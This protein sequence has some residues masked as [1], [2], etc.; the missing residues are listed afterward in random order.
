MIQQVKKLIEEYEMIQEGDKVVLGVSGGADSVCLLRVLLEL[1]EELD[2]QLYVAHI[3]HGI[4]GEASL[5]DAEF[6]KQLCRRFSLP[7]FLYS[8]PVLELA[9]EKRISVEEAGRQVRYS[10]F[11]ELAEKIGG[12]KIAVAH[13]GNDV[14]ETML[15]HLARGTGLRGLAGIAPV[16][17]NIIRPLLEVTREE[18]LNYLEEIQQD[19]CTD[20]TNDMVDYARNRIRHQVLPALEQIN[21]KAIPHMIRTGRYVRENLKEQD[22]ILKHFWREYVRE[23]QGTIEICNEF[24]ECNGIGIQSVLVQEA[25]CYQSGHRK[26]IS[27]A[28]I[29]AVIHLYQ[30]QIGK[31]VDLPYG[32]EACRQYGGILLEKHRHPQEEQPTQEPMELKVPG[33]TRLLNGKVMVTTKILERK[34]DFAEIPRKKYTKWFDY[35]IIKNT[36][37]VRT[38]VAGDYL[39]VD[40]NG[41]RKK[42][43]EYLINEKVPQNQREQQLLIA[44]GSLVHWVVGLR[45]GEDAKVKQDT[46]KILEIQINGGEEYERD[47]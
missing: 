19:Y 5:Q 32:M 38:R 4:R 20:Q 13:N 45:I 36:L 42:L 33:V 10:S 23:E 31:T 30:G 37:Q 9:K 12:G 2:I 46:R 15:F 17:N 39:I 18:I 27:A 47:N 14:A 22:E 25:I 29:E 7:F 44:E 3:E 26:D 6:V 21:E 8:Y 24:F 41:G 16:R 11:E 1:R 40:E 35:D 34:G 28:H 43:K